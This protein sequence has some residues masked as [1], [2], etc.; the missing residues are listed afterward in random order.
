MTGLSDT[1]MC[2][3]PKNTF[4]TILDY[5]NKILMKAAS[6]KRWLY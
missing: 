3:K 1:I 4:A 5:I 2:E 6:P